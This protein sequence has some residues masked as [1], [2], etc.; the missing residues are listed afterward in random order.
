MKQQYMPWTEQARFIR[1]R[2]RKP[3]EVDGKQWFPTVTAAAQIGIEPKTLQVLARLYPARDKIVIAEN[4]AR[5]IRIPRERSDQRPPLYWDID[6]L[7]G[8]Y[9]KVIE[10]EAE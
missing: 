5:F 10:K 8:I 4:G 3:I 1:D 9:G 2:M 7:R 6:S